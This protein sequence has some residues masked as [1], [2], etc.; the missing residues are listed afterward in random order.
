[1]HW[2]TL[3]AAVPLLI[4][5]YLLFAHG[6]F[7]SLREDIDQPASLDHWPRVVAI[8]PARNEAAGIAACVSALARQ[9]YPGDFSIVVVDDHSADGTAALARKAAEESGASVRVAIH[10][11][12]NLPQG[13]TGKLWALNEG[14]SLAETQSPQFFWFTDGD[15]VHSPD[16]LR[17]LVSRAETNHLD[18]A[19][20]TTVDAYADGPAV[21]RV[22]ND[23]AHLVSG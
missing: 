1:M 18:L 19:S 16:T 14:A 17:R 23:T 15:I 8:V 22:F 13:W 20:L 21:L 7:W 12:S 3:L 9:D 4:W 6:S 2:N 11:A 10:A 5:I